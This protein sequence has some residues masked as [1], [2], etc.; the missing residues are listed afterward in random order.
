MRL[1]FKFT[2]LK[3]NKY[4]V[5][6]SSRYWKFAT[7]NNTCPCRSTALMSPMSVSM[8]HRLYLSKNGGRLPNLEPYSLPR[9]VSLICCRIYYLL[10]VLLLLIGILKCWSMNFYSWSKIFIKSFI[11]PSS[12]SDFILM[13]T[14]LRS[15]WTLCVPDILRRNGSIWLR[16]TLFVP[17][18]LRING[19]IWLSSSFNTLKLYDQVL[20]ISL[21]R[22][23]FPKVVLYRI[24]HKLRSSLFCAS[25]LTSGLCLLANPNG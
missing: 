4:I 16:W 14:R 13:G 19:S 11:G 20:L 25:Y 3:G 5:V 15:R 8:Y 2:F 9:E 22:H 17:D 12:I 23:N 7:S 24:L 21:I 6:S 18:I 1:W 10:W